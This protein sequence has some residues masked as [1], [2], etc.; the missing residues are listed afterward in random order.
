MTLEE[1]II[2]KMIETLLK[3]IKK[4]K[5]ILILFITSTVFFIFQHANSISWDFCSY[6]L[7]AKY[8]FSQGTYFELLRPPLA[9]LI[10]GLFGVFGWRAAEFIF[11]IFTSILFCYSSNKFAKTV[12]LSPTAFYALS[13]NTYLLLNGLI[14]GTELLALAFLE[15]FVSYLIEN[16]S[17]SGLFLGLSALSRYTGL[18]LVP[19]LVFH[20][21]I[22]NIF[23]SLIWFGATVSGWFVYNLIKTGNF[24]TSVADQYA[25]NILYRQYLMQPVNWNHFIEVQQV[26][27]P[28]FII[29]VIIVL[30]KIIRGAIV[31]KIKSLRDILKYVD[32]IKAELIMI[33]LLAYFCISYIQ[34][35]IKSSRYLFS[36]MLPTIYFS[37]IGIN[38]I[39]SKIKGNKNMLKTIILIIIVINVVTLIITTNKLEYESTPIYESAITQLDELNLSQCETSSNSWVMLSYLGQHSI[40]ALQKELV[41]KSIENNQTIILFNHVKEPTYVDDK[42]FLKTLPIL[43]KNDRY[44]IISNGHCKKISKFDKT[45]LRLKAEGIY[46][47]A[48]YHININPCHIIFRNKEILER[49]CNYINFN[50]FSVDENRVLE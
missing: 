16:K 41:N 25:N 24:F 47:L 21:K 45:Y 42:N 14:N 50:G 15:L 39:L 18:A 35:P 22:K 8:L 10:I 20:L 31:E 19:L 9:P 46:E 2:L 28:F 7:N 12:N 44:V 48:N 11:I 6:V 27:I 34:T 13:L 43:Y 29:G 33:I 40:P 3:F 23:K 4:N 37:V 17:K 32:K 5:I 30:Y 38:Y 1:S 36:F 49:T 26:L